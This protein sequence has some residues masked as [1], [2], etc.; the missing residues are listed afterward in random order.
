M[1]D[2]NKLLFKLRAEDR[3]MRVL[4]QRTSDSARELDGRD[5]RLGLKATLA[6]LTLWDGFAVRFFEAKLAGGD[7]DASVFTRFETS[8][9]HERERLCRLPFSD[10]FAAY[11]RATADLESFLRRRWSDLSVK[12]RRDFAIPV[13]HHK[14]HRQLLA[15]DLPGSESGSVPS[16]AE[17]EA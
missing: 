3:Q 8:R 12:E 6:H 15:G 16:E 14:H 11:E 17:A 5:G 10:V 13:R 2:L 7:A 4:V 9:R 1:E